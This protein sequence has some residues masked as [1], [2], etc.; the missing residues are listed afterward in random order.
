MNYNNII[1]KFSNQKVLIIGDVM[2]DTYVWGDVKR[3]SP[4]APV[5][6]LNVK[7]KEERLG[8]AANVALNTR[9]LGAETVVC[10]VV[11]DDD[12]AE[13]LKK[14]ANLHN[15]SLNM[16]EVKDRSTSVKTRV[17]GGNQQVIRVDEEDTSSVS[18]NVLFQLME[19]IE[20]ELENGVELIIFQD[21]DK[22][23][24]N[25]EFIQQVI[26]KAKEKEVKVSADPKKKHFFCFENVDL[27]KPNLKEL[28][29]GLNIG[30]GHLSNNEIIE[31]V[32]KLR[33]KMPHSKTLVSLASKG[34]YYKDDNEKEKFI[35]AHVREV[36]DVS[37]AGDTVISVASMA[38]LAGGS[39]HELAELS[40]IAGGLVCEELG[41]TPINVDKLREE[42][43]LSNNN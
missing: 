36:A 43:S 21:Y 40:N 33:K 2:L 32:S 27:F 24:L 8:G 41:V 34:M 28:G 31:C 42:A 22:G 12:Q 35:P 11:G 9:S 10:S 3:I 7:G 37:G 20:K 29:E 17:I 25:R 4:E 19:N 23:V 39:C 30:G 38:L 6:V 1:N 18:N 15:I 13:R 5:P 16:L 14:L 26:A